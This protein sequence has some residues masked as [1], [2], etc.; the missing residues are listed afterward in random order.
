MGSR[1][2]APEVRGCMAKHVTVFCFTQLAPGRT[3][4]AGSAQDD[5]ICRRRIQHRRLRRFSSETELC[6]AESGQIFGH[7]PLV[8]FGTCSTPLLHLCSPPPRAGPKL[9]H[10]RMPNHEHY[11]CCGM[12]ELRGDLPLPLSHL[13]RATSFEQE[14][15]HGSALLQRHRRG[16]ARKQTHDV[17]RSPDRLLSCQ[18]ALRRCRSPYLRGQVF[19]NPGSQQHTPTRS[20]NY[21]KAWNRKFETTDNNNTRYPTTPPANAEQSRGVL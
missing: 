9:P 1:K 16:R 17:L 14:R 10:N 15:L 11:G 5:K 18:G 6:E 3:C 2:L 8:T 12:P 13:A 19:R 7:P 20:S 4:R 21:V